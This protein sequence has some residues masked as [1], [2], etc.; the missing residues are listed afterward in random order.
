[1]KDWADLIRALASLLWPILGFT[2]TSIFKNELRE[3]LKRLKRGKILGQEVELHE[4]LDYL[5]E[6]ASA[7]AAELAASTTANNADIS[8]P[9]AVENELKQIDVSQEILRIAVS[10]P[11]ASLM[12]LSSEI[13]KE[14]TKHMKS[15]NL[16]ALLGMREGPYYPFIKSIN[17]LEERGKLPSDVMNVVRDF[18]SIRNNIVHGNEVESNDILRAIDSGITILKTLQAIPD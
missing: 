7:V 4:S 6:K 16:P 1:M 5:Q 12:L 11:K 10:S 18:W 3:L 15:L 13:E 14:L 2:V 8:S 9:E 17:I